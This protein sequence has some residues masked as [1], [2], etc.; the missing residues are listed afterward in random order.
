MSEHT[1]R[2]VYRPADFTPPEFFNV[3]KAAVIPRPIAWVVSK[4][5][6][7]VLNLAPH[8]F[9][10]LVS[11]KP[12]V[13]AFSS[14][15]MKDTLRNI[16]ETKDFVVHI[17]T[18]ADFDACNE[19]SAN[20][21]PEESEI[22]ALGLATAPSTVVG[23]PR[24][25]DSPVSIECRLHEVVDVGAGQ[26]I[27]GEVVHIEIDNAVLRED[28]RGRVLPDA[29]KLAP[30]TRMGRDEWGTLGEVWRAPDLRNAR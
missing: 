14:V 24:L 26:L 2:K 9:F 7:G 1:D 11:P 30:I 12:P 3:L 15:G 28:E 25:A 19:S 21:P 10:N 16:T 20:Y 22:A 8:S 13:L 4:S 29:H 18:E 6:D 5:A 27:L 23:A 17:P